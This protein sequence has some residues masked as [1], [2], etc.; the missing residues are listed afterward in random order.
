[1]IFLHQKLH[2]NQWSFYKDFEDVSKSLNSGL[3]NTQE[4]Y[5]K[6]SPII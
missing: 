3:N 6:R 5:K 1:M 4:Q 2:E